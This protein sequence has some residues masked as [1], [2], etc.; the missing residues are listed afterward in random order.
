MGLR[1]S[2]LTL[3]KLFTR[4]LA[5]VTVVAVMMAA[6]CSG[7]KGSADETGG[8]NVMEEARFLRMSDGKGYV[9]AEVV[10]PWD[11][12][13]L[14]GRY[15]LVERGCEPD[16]LPEGDYEKVVVPVER[17]L[18]YSSV[19]GGVIDELGA[20]GR[21]GGVA[22][23]GYFTKEPLAGRIRRG[24]VKDVGSSMAP[25]LEAVLA[26]GAD[27][28]LISP[29]E[30]AGH[31]V[32]GQTGVPIVECA[33][34]M[35]MT[36]KGRAEWVKLLGVLFGER[37][38][39]DSLY[40]A[41]SAAYDSIAAVARGGERHPV[42]LT[43]QLQDGYWFVP[44]GRSYMARMIA[45]AGGCYP[46]ADDGSVG[47]LQL[48]FPSVYA[49]AGEADVWLIR[50]YGRDVTL[51]ALRD[52]YPLNSRF[53]AYRTG[54]VWGVNTAEVPLYDEFPFHPELLLEDYARIFSG[55]TTGLRYYRK[56]R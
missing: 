52:T 9:L 6:G 49:R 47:S 24:E 54:G 14:L 53:K 42:V 26:L 1:A 38:R 22:D 32:V 50:S 41:V 35:E 13:S 5:V 2:A 10:N 51:G 39:A 29:F 17:A 34:Y 33:D 37:E 7:G 36:P 18:V 44:G 30:N 23:G 28:M 16:S 48:D 31:G 43:E 19:H 12:T 46:W 27:V 4:A 25:S 40:A 45:D 15:L 8:R 56:V 3:T 20:G 11:T 55:D 21:I